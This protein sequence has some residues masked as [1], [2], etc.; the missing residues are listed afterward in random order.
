M[1]HGY[2]ILTLGKQFTNVSELS[3][4]R[5]AE[6]STIWKCS[7]HRSLSV[8]CPQTTSVLQLWPWQQF[9]SMNYIWFLTVVYKI[10]YNTL[11]LY[12][13]ISANVMINLSNICIKCLSTPP[14]P[15]VQVATSNE[16]GVNAHF[17]HS[18]WKLLHL[19]VT[20]KVSTTIFGV[21]IKK[22]GVAIEH[23]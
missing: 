4:K 8:F 23:I 3:L 7:V 22:K 11:N 15:S 14:L 18:H 9:L 10:I 16:I 13:K 12:P 2:G 17:R 6:Q 5:L 1:H 20:M 19:C 21:C